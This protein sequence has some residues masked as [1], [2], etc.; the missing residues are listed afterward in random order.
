MQKVQSRRY[1]YIDSIRGLAALSVVL[2]HSYALLAKSPQAL[3]VRA[4]GFAQEWF[5]FGKFGVAL[6]FIVSGF[7]VPFSLRGETGPGLRRFTISRFFRLYPV[8]WL[9]ILAALLLDTGIFHVAPATPIRHFMLDL[10]PSLSSVLINLTMLQ[11]FFGVNNL[12]TVFWT[13]QLELIFYGL[14]ALLFLLGRLE[15]SKWLFSCACVSL[16]GA[17]ALAFL[18]YET[19]KKLPVA[20]PIAMVLMLFGALYRRGWLDGGV[21]AKKLA[22]TLGILFLCAMPIIAFFGYNRDSG[23]NETWYV[24]VA[25]YYAAIGAFVLMTTV[26]RLESPFFVWMGRISYSMYLFHPLVIVF[27]RPRLDALG[28][29]FS[30]SFLIIVATALAL[31]HASYKWLEAPAIGWG[32][33]LSKR[34][35]ARASRIGEQKLR[36]T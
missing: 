30:L 21:Q 5:S 4:L 34:L 8:Y 26:A 29:P 13:L 28:L 1:H 18:R 7:V 9:A 14:C 12:V 6:F 17:V 3:D 15:D 25:S 32:R 16:V 31:S 22:R 19:E 33:A 10:T 23:F 2:E 27:L 36:V 20:L 24:Y 11:Q 35:E